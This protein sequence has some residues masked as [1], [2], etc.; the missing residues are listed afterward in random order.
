MCHDT[1]HYLLVKQLQVN[2]NVFHVII[3]QARLFIVKNI[4]FIVDHVFNLLLM[5]TK[6]VLLKVIINKIIDN[7]K[8]IEATPHTHN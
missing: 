5:I 1:L 4:I 7:A 8:A 2:I 6:N 3:Y